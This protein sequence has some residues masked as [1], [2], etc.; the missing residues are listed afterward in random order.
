MKT[1]L[2][3]RAYCLESEGDVVHSTKR[4]AFELIG[5]SALRQL[6]PMFPGDLLQD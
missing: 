2:I 4:K 3:I 6:S 1:L 5:E